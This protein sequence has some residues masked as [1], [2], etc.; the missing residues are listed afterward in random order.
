MFRVGLVTKK[1]GIISENFETREEADDY[2]LT[3]NE[4]LEVRYAR[5]I[6]KE[7]GKREVVNF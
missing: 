1:G 6:N 3:K 5:I 2:I 7:T 4:E